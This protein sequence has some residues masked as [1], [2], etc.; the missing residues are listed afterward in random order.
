MNIIKVPVLWLKLNYFEV[1]FSK[2]KKKMAE[3]CPE[4]PEYS[5]IVT[6]RLLQRSSLF[7]RSCNAYFRANTPP[8]MWHPKLNEE[9][10]GTFEISCYN[11]G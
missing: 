11:S 1:K 5:T 4:G 2:K 8:I 10:E 6:F 3:S 9:G 7:L